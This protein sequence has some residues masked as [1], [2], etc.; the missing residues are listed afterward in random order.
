MV[1][2]IL[3]GAGFIKQVSGLLNVL[4]PELRADFG[5]MVLDFIE[6][7]VEGTKSPIDDM[8]VLPIT[9]SIRDMYNIPDND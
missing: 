2:Q 4:S 1:K 9:K 8:L 6:N 3:K 7:K 5:D